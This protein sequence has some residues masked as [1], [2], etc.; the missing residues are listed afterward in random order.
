[1]VAAIAESS[2][3]SGPTMETKVLPAREPKRPFSRKPMNGS[4]GINQRLLSIREPAARGSQF[5]E[6]LLSANRQP[7]TANFFLPADRRE[8]PRQL[9]FFTS[10]IRI[11]L[12]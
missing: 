12:R 5:A 10:A 11:I 7:R 4:A 8:C 2:D 3:D 9:L 1:M 6:P